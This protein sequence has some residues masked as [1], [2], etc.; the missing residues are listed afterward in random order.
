M[1]N[2]TLSEALLNAIQNPDKYGV[3]HLNFLFW[4][5]ADDHAKQVYLAQYRDNPVL[6][7]FFQ[8]RYYAPDYDFE[9]LAALPAD[10]LG[11]AFYHHLTDNGL[12]PKLLTNYK[13]FQ[14][15]EDAAGKLPNMPDEIKYSTVRGF[16]THDILHAVTGMDTSPLGEIR[17]QAFG[18]AQSPNVY[19]AFWMSMLTTGSAFLNPQNIDPFMD[20]ITT[21]WQLGRRAKSLSVV[22]W[23]EMFDRPLA[24]LQREYNLI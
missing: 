9:S 13:A 1:I 10:T 4:Q 21:G 22:H 23:E 19:N 18:L 3:P 17:L 24:E 6:R 8:E 14:E 16:Q 2:S 5:E 12:D 11:Y 20:A 7:R 15:A